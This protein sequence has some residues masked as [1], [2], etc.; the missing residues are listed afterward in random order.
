M[1]TAVI[2]GITVFLPSKSNSCPIPVFRYALEFWEEDSYRVDV[3]YQNSLD[4]GEKELL[5]YLLN[6]SSR[7]NNMKA[8]LELRSINASGEMDDITRGFLS[9]LSPPE[10]PWIVVRF[11]RVSGINKVIWS[12]PLNK[13]NVQNL[14][15]SP[16]RESI[17]A[18]LAGNA[19]AVWV[20]LE[21]GDRSKDR[22]TYDL[23]YNELRRLEQTL[24]LPDLELWYENTSGD[25]D[26]DVPVIN[27]EIVTLSRSDV[28]EEPFVKMLV[29]TE[30]D[31]LKFDSEPIVFPFYGRGIALWAIVGRGINE[32][33]IMDAAE[34]LTGPCSCQAKLLNPGT[35]ML[36]SMN[37]NNVVENITDISLANPLSGMGDF[38]SRE[39]EAR[40]QLE[41]AT[42]K[43]FG[44]TTNQRESWTTDSDKVVYIDIFGKEK[45]QVQSG[46]DIEKVE[47]VR[48][49]QEVQKDKI[50]GKENAGNDSRIADL[51]AQKKESPEGTQ[52]MLQEKVSLENDA[53]RKFGSTQIL[54]SVLGGIIALVLLSGIIL[55]RRH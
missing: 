47:E 7:D 19:T 50:A 2:L 20:L 25:P 38:A 43:R 10:L 18:K 54:L 14:V 30:D 8:N 21:S 49:E 45:D 1:V 13:E 11:P 23:L 29:N 12:G 37:W 17:A 34:F 52:E 48:E 4:A 15:N 3:F 9:N 27:F 22:K 35:D 6:A 28:R 42:N 39:A 32:W 46:E 41:S 33:N 31:L 51:P 40:S 26:A 55:Y 5:N 44:T 16:A 36:L 24:V 53:K